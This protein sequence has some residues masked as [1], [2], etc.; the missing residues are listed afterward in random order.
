MPSPGSSYISSHMPR[1][2]GTLLLLFS[3]RVGIQICKFAHSNSRLPKLNKCQNKSTKGDLLKCAN[4][5]ERKDVRITV[6]KF[7][8]MYGF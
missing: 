1:K 2:I 4:E 7:E 5:S 8:G 3:L 6:D